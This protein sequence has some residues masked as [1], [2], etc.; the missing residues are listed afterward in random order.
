MAAVELH[1]DLIDFPGAFAPPVDLI[2]VV[3]DLHTRHSEI[4]GLDQL[5]ARAQGRPAEDVA[6]TLRRKGWLSPLR[7]RGVWSFTPTLSPLH[8]GEFRELRAWLLTHQE[9]GV[10]IAGK[11]AAQVHGWLRRP[12]APTIGAPSEMRLPRSLDEYRVCRWDP[13]LSLDEVHGLPAWQP[14]TLLVFMAARPAQFSWDGISDWLWELAS[15]VDTEMLVTE[16]YGRKRSVWMKTAH[17]V[18]ESDS[19]EL[20]AEIAAQAPATGHGP[21]QFGQRRAMDER[22]GL[23]PR[24]VPEFEVM[25]YVLPTWWTA[26]L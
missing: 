12:T 8:M 18:N 17:L 19:P 7:T 3:N 23:P 15:S 20:A 1:P 14:E 24:W 11:S 5:S 10:C 6:R 16:L 21:Y 4:V 9:S 13:N 26:R 25:D 22:F 2:S